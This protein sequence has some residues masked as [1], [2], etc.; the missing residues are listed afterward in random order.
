MQAEEAREK[1][2]TV[3]LENALKEAEQEVMS[4][5]DMAEQKAQEAIDLIVSQ[6]V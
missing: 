4:L 6:L 3:Y 1:D 5:K 2:G